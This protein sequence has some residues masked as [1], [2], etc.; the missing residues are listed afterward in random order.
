MHDIQYDEVHD[1]M[2]IANP[3]AQAILTYRGGANGEEPPIRVLQGPHTQ[4]SSPDFGVEVDPVHDELFVAEADSVLVFSRAANGD[5]APLRVLRGPNT[6]LSGGPRAVS[7]DPLHNLLIVST[8]LKHV[9]RILIFN[10]TDDGD[11]KPRAVIA[12]PNTGIRAHINYA[13]VYP[14]KGW[15]VTTLGSSEA[16][17][18]EGVSEGVGLGQ[19]TGGS[20]AVWSIQDNGDVAPRWILGGPKSNVRSSRIALNPKA[21]E[22]MV[23]GG[24]SIRT[25]YFPEIF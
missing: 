23:G 20:I 9:G 2:I 24:T 13:R 12:G 15:I 14:P 19:N 6:Q 7:V 16:E 5:A 22:V 1:E 21:K 4:I 3:F 18:G 25:W 11:A 10:R 17:G 8:E